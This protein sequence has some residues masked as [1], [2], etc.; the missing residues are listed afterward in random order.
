MTERI[1]PVDVVGPIRSGA[2][3]AGCRG[4]RTS[5][6][7]HGDGVKP[8]R[9]QSTL[10]S[11]QGTN[12]AF[13]L[14]PSGFPPDVVAVPVLQVLHR[15]PSSAATEPLWFCAGTSWR[16]IRIAPGQGSWLPPTWTAP[17]QLTT[18]KSSLDVPRRG[19]DAQRAVAVSPVGLWHDRS[20][21]RG[22]DQGQPEDR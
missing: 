12:A 10:L 4:R 16:T 9:C 11:S 18:V 19:T 22:Q 21:P 7:R 15:A 8:R 3:T 17:N 2:L 20:G 5:P 14:T 6:G 13:V 1:I